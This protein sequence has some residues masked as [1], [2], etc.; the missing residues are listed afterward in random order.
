MVGWN[1][2]PKQLVAQLLLKDKCFIL[3]LCYLFMSLIV[4]HELCVFENDLYVVVMNY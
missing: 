3:F 1:V 2:H 4:V